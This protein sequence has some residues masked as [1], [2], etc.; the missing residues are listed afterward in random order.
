VS[1]P[2]EPVGDERRRA[3]VLAELATHVPADP[4]EERALA[5]T[6][7]MTGWLRSP[8][9]EAADA[10]HLTG[11]AIVV[12]GTGRVVLHR[13]KRL[14]LWLQP[15][16][17]IDPGELA[18][19][20]ARRETLEE[21]GLATTHPGGRPRLVHVDVHPAPR[22]HLH[23]DLRYLLVADGTSALAPAAGESPDVAWFTPE[24]ACDVTD[25]SASAAVRAA[26]RHLHGG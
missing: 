2:P 20:A 14:G 12:D 4:V 5:R 16:G 19:E 22:G 23:L 18:S 25:A 3:E 8:F 9:D 21:T 13:H 11:S 1:A 24:A 26:S 7:A 15:G 6:R 10:T 17:H